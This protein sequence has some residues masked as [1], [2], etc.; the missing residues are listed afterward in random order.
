MRRACAG[1]VLSSIVFLAL[2]A[3]RVLA[4][5]APESGHVPPEPASQPMPPMSAA[6]MERV[7]DMHDDP[8]LAMFKLDQFER[9]WGDGASATDWEAEAWIGHAFDKLWLR[10]EGEREAGATDARVE[11]LWDHAFASFWDWQLGVRHDFGSGPP[12][13][14]PSAAEAMDG[15]ERPRRDWAA[16]GVQGLAP[17]WFEIEA[18][19]YVGPSG[20]TAFRFRA[21]YEL[22]LTQRLVLQPELEANLYGKSDPERGIGDGLSDAAVGLRLRYEIRREIAPYVGVVWKHRY[23]DVASAGR[24]AAQMQFVAGLRVWF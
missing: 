20:R 15:R 14:S 4:Q 23:G 3:L 12:R 13:R 17:Y 5:D 24:D 11:A 9:A 19:A 8:L 1:R 6:E 7:M 2:P 22:L 16:F 10:S 21:E 18:T